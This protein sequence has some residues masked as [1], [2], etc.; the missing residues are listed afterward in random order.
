MSPKAGSGERDDW[1]G[2]TGG[3]RKRIPLAGAGEKDDLSGS[4]IVWDDWRS[5]GED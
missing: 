4:S 5:S 3:G 1:A 2:V